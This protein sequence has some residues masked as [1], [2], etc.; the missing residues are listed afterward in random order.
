MRK[1]PF[2]FTD[3]NFGFQTMQVVSSLLY[4]ILP[5][6]FTHRL[7]SGFFATSDSPTSS[8]PMSR[9]QFANSLK[10]KT[11]I[12]KDELDICCHPDIRIYKSN[13]TGSWFETISRF[14][15]S[16]SEKALFPANRSL[17]FFCVRWAD[18][19]GKRHLCHGSK[20]TLIQPPSTTLD[21]TPQ[22]ACLMICFLTVI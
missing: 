9:S 12:Q 11:L 6:L 1:N 21:G 20:L 5:T 3:K 18:E 13:C 17:F 19:Y 16:S 7:L 22:T 2:I 4:R 8:S 15:A 14:L 10:L